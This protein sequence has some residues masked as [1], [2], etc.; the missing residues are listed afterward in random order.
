MLEAITQLPDEY[1]DAVYLYYYEGY[2][3]AEIADLKRCPEATI[4]SRLMRARKRLAAL[5][6]GVAK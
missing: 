2:T 3:T 1:K 6:G 5:L 4:R